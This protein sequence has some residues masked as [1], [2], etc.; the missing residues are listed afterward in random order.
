MSRILTVDGVDYDVAGD[1]AKGLSVDGFCAWDLDDDCWLEFH[2]WAAQPWPTW[3]GRRDVDYR[4]DGV[5]VFKGVTTL[6]EP[7]EKS[8]MIWGYRCQG[9]KYLMNQVRIQAPDYSGEIAYNLPLIDEESVPTRRGKSVGEIIAAVLT[10]HSA[11]LAGYGIFADA[12]TASQLAAL[13]LVPHG[14]QTLQGSFL[15]TEIESTLR[16][17]AGNVKMAILPTGEIRFIDAAGLETLGA[18]A[19]LHVL[20]YGVDEVHP[21]LIGRE[22]GAAAPRVVCYGK[23]RVFPFNGRMDLAPSELQPAWDSDQQDEWSDADFTRPGDASDFGVVTTTGGPTTI[24]IQSDDPARTWPVN[25]WNKRGAWVQLRNMTEVGLN[26]QVD[27]PV[28]ACTALTAGGTSTLTLGIELEN[29]A[30]DAWETYQLVGTTGPLVDDGSG[31]SLNNVWRLFNIVTPGGLVEDHLAISSPVPLPFYGLN[32]SST[33]MV[34]GPAANIVKNGVTFPAT[35]RPLTETGQILFDEPIV[36]GFNSRETLEAGG[37]AVEPPDDILFMVPYARGPLTIAYPP[38]VG[39]VPQYAGTSHTE[40]GMTNTMF[41]YLPEWRYEGNSPL[42][43]AYAE[44]IHRTV[45]DVQRSATAIHEGIWDD[46]MAPGDGH[47]VSFAAECGTTGNETL[48]IP[49]RSVVVRLP[50][51][52]RVVTEIRMTNRVEWRTDPGAFIHSM[53]RIG[54][55]NPIGL[56]MNADFTIGANGAQRLSDGA[57][58]D[59][60]IT[61]GKPGGLGGMTD[62]MADVGLGQ[63]PTGDDASAA[64]GQDWSAPGGNVSGKYAGPKKFSTPK[65]YSTAKLYR[66]TKTPYRKPRK[67]SSTTTAELAAERARAKA[68]RQAASSDAE[69]G[70]DDR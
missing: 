16:R 56:P 34:F 53:G 15:G 44:L 60:G 6:V 57:Q 8:G 39:G 69:G 62:T 7:N 43:Q 28:T 12:T 55:G 2:E 14:E 31:T 61:A 4:R 21:P 49:V 32:N 50:E 13:T 27:V 36:R 1:N 64:M 20:T 40:G 23:A 3:P 5:L 58:V 38:D 26:Y 59:F 24:T 29:S 19:E 17:W 45:C 52:G 46:G 47:K 42:I 51:D 41:V 11:Q 48:A 65:K 68:R 30:S 22:W 37:G 25:F 35:F 18:T 54:S 33:A 10:M 70:E 66:T 9:L 67:Y 63:G